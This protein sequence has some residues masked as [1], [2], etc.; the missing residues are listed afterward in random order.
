MLKKKARLFILRFWK[1]KLFQ[2]LIRYF[3]IAVCSWS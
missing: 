2:I 3:W 1:G